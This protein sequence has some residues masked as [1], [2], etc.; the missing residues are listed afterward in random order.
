MIAHEVTETKESIVVLLKLVE[1]W[2]SLSDAYTLACCL[3][4][5]I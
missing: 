4:M 3:I 2:Q 5:V 1:L